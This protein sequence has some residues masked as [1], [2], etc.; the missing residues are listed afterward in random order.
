[1][2][3]SGFG[4]R[5]ILVSEWV[6]QY[7]LCF[8]LLKEI[9]DNFFLKC[10]LEFIHGPIWACYFLF[11][12]AVIDSISLIDIGLFRLSIYSYMS[13]GRLCLSRNQT[14]SSSLSNI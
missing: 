3:L 5:V 11:W 1:M 2:S 9:V 13:F 4:I 10:L 6:R 7:S 12:K 14:I 8:C